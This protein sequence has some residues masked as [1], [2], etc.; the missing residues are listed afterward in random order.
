M[1]RL[2]LILSVIFSIIFFIPPNGSPIVIALSILIGVAVSLLAK[3]FIKNT[4]MLVVRTVRIY[5][6]VLVVATMLF[7]WQGILD[8]FLVAYIL[9]VLLVVEF[10]LRLVRI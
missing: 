10:F 5:L 3:I 2:L 7:Q 9:L 6:P 8:L 4:N 1:W